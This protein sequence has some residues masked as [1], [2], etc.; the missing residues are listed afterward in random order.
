MLHDVWTL[1]NKKEE[2]VLRRKTA[3]FD[4][5]AFSKKEITDLVTRMRRIMLK[6][7]GIGL[8]ANQIG[9]NLNMFVAEI[10]DT[11]GGTK[12]YAVFNPKIEKMSD[13]KVIYEEGCLSVPGTWGDVERPD[14]I[15]VAGFD[16]TGKPAKIKARGLLARVF[17]HELDHLNGKLFIDKAKNLHHSAPNETENTKG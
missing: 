1:D 3:D 5:A 8:S 15:I 9:L 17:Q 7:N 11:T 4:F 2:K 6:A 16:K 12:F 10:P 13:D 14:K